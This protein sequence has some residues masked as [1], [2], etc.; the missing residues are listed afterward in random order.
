MFGDG[1]YRVLTWTGAAMSGADQ[2]D[3]PQNAQFRGIAGR[4]LNILYMHLDMYRLYI[5]DQGHPSIGADQ[6]R[7]RSTHTW[8][9]PSL[10]RIYF[11]PLHS[12]VDVRFR[13]NR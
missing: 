4:K 3:I 13:K 11:T 2:F 7:W 10:G 8:G 6:G 12:N 1:A 5:F 9:I